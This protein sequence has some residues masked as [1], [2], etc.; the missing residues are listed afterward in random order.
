MAWPGPR[1]CRHMLVLVVGCGLD[2]PTEEVEAAKSL[3][4]AAPQT[5]MGDDPRITPAPNSFDEWTDATKVRSPTLIS[6]AT[7]DINV[8]LQAIRE[9]PW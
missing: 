2:A 7:H 9:P 5:L 1:G 3:A 4:K 6:F 8:I